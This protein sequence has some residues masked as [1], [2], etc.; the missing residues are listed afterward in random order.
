MHL[1]YSLLLTTFLFGYYGKVEPLDTYTIKSNVTGKVLLA[2]SY[3]EG[4]DVKNSL[5]VKVDDF[6]DKIDLKNLLKQKD[7]LSTQLSL[8]KNI[9]NE[10][11][12]TLDIKKYNYE[13]Y[14]DLK[15]KSKIEK[16][17]K[18]LEYITAKISIE[19]T[20]ITIENIKNQL[21]SINASIDKLKKSIKDKL[22]VVNGYLYQV[23]VKKDEFISLGSSILTVMDISKTKISIFIPI[24]E[25]EKIKNRSIYI[26]DK[27][28]NFTISKIF[29]VADEKYVTS[30][31]VEI[32]GNYDK[33]SDVVK[34]EFK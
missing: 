7:I 27:K 6:N 13:I 5:I 30:Y 17:A 8:Y 9:L 15:T 12:Q 16:D 20:K 26:N 23:L 2:N 31:K 28:S 22:I 18:F 3:L 19:Q 24:N 4:E 11:N 29:K 32:I 21:S 14:K 1:I 25:I 33:I 34:V 10:Q